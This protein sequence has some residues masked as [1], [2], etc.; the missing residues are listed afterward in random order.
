MTPLLFPQV[1]CVGVTVAVT[2]AFT[3]TGRKTPFD[4]HDPSPKRKILYS[5]GA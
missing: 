1:V 5:P 4:L 3:V 2:A